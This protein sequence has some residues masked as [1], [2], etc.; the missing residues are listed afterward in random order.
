[1][2]ALS[3]TPVEQYKRI[4]G[5]PF[6]QNVKYR[7]C[8]IVG[9]PGCGKTTLIEKI[10]GWPE[11]GYI[12]LSIK[13]WWASQ[14]LAV[15]PREV[16]F[17]L[18]FEGFDQALTVYDEQWLAAAQPLVLDLS[19]IRLPPVKKHFF[20]VDWRGRFVFE[21]LM[22]E[23]ETLLQRRLIR[24]EAKTHFVDQDL[25]LATIRRQ[26]EVFEQ[27]AIHFHLNGMAV[28]VRKDFD[29]PPSRI[30]NNRQCRT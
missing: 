17:G 28:F 27:V 6:A 7:Q 16:H 4:K 9:P 14:S 11:E 5:I 29:D 3:L 19:R 1:M 12:D 30:V 20:S 10:G 26:V 22:P 24:A 25:N 23:P 21:F 13:P 2:N 18:P 15:R 8:L